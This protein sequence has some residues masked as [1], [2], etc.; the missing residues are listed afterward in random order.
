[1]IY[2]KNKKATFDYTLK[3]KF[4]AG[5]QLF[6]WEVKSI[7]AGKL[8]L[9]DSYV[10]IKHNAAWLLG[11]VIQPIATMRIQNFDVNRTRKLLLKH[12]EIK[13]LQNGKQ[14]K[15]LTIVCLKVYKVRHLIKAEIALAQGNKTYDKRENIKRR[16]WERD[17]RRAFKLQ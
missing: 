3:K 12:S 2:A 6:G 15:G 1:V 16:E 10:I 14:Q 11:S 13:Q 9:V 7:R 17:K 8:Q 5:I 4:E